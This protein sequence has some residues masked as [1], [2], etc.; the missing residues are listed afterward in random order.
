[1]GRGQVSRQGVAV[2]THH[3]GLEAPQ[4]VN[5]PPGAHDDDDG[6]LVYVVG[7]QRDPPVHQHASACCLMPTFVTAEPSRREF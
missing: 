3:Q 1:M 5:N 7:D 6:S 2:S 4:E